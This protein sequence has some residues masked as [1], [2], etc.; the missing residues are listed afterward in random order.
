MHERLGQLPEQELAK[1]TQA[2]IKPLAY[3]SGFI[4]V[5]DPNGLAIPS[6]LSKEHLSLYRDSEKDTVISVV[7][8]EPVGP[9]LA[10]GSITFTDIIL[11]PFDQN[12]FIR[13]GLRRN[14]TFVTDGDRKTYF[15]PSGEVNFEREYDIHYPDR[16]DLDLVMAATDE[17]RPL[18]GG[19]ETTESGETRPVTGFSDDPH[20]NAQ[21]NVAARK[22]HVDLLLDGPLKRRTAQEV[23]ESRM[24]L[25][26]L[27]EL[28]DKIDIERDVI[29]PPKI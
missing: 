14:Y 24:R 22:H 2:R 8:N 21:I 16:P 4:F 29:Y 19:I 1:Q 13:N 20:Q 28:L 5:I 23:E 25:L 6:H 3:R 15:V 7:S 26:E 18:I 10:S 12:T 9:M 17:P 11:D 27:N